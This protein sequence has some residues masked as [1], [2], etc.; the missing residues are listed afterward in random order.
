MITEHFSVGVL[1]ATECVLLILTVY[2]W[3]KSKSEN[4]R[5]VPF[6]R[7][8][9]LSACACLIEIIYSSLVN[10]HY[11]MPGIFY[12]SLYELNVF[13]GMIATC[14]LYLYFVQFLD[15]PKTERR[16]LSLVRHVVIAAELVILL[17]NFVTGAVVRYNTSGYFVMGPLYDTASYV[18]PFYFIIIIIILAVLHFRQFD[19]K[20]LVSF[21]IVTGISVLFYPIQML[22]FPNVLTEYFI[23]GLFAVVMFFA[24]ETSPVNLLLDTEQRLEEAYAKT[25]RA[26]RAALQAAHTKSDFLSNMSHEIRTPMNAIIGMNDMILQ[27]TKS[28][29]TR[30]YAEEIRDSGKHL[31]HVINDILDYSR[32]ESGRTEIRIGA[33]SLSD[34]LRRLFDA[35]KE[36]AKDKGLSFSVDAD[37]TLP[38]SLIG[39]EDRLFQ[40]VCNLLENAVKYTERGSVKLT[41][42]G[43]R[44]DMSLTLF[45]KVSDTGI[46]IGKESLKG[47]FESFSRAN[48]ERNRNILGTGLGLAITKELVSMM[49]GDISVRSEEG[50]GSTFTIRIAQKILSDVPGSSVTDFLMHTGREEKESERPVY[51]GARVLIVDDNT[52]NLR[53][54]S[55]LLK[56]YGIDAQIASSGEACL[57][58]CADAHFD[59]VLLDHLMPE[60]DG[61]QTLRALRSSAAFNKEQTTVV[62]LTAVDDPGAR[63]RFIGMGFDDFLTKPID[64][65]NLE[66]LLSAYLT[67]EH[68]HGI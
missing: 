60:M 48:I 9:T 14:S 4:I 68:A 47:I 32:M 42:N 12:Q 36:S 64:T 2:L 65:K 16:L 53:I 46:G 62:A 61:E 15:A 24:L 25:D 30:A 43:V 58:E 39:D 67:K 41:V 23:V 33:Y 55:M 18:L 10:I 38:D 51:D 29:Q 31:L 7:F 49:G 45:F 17:A 52:V 50:V 11:S 37:R 40:V 59:I 13:M 34:L 57:K 27:E 21:G 6:R 44:R 8:V 63:E 3:S 35:V 26:T 19:K 28:V 5:F 54:A 22:F 1:C 66:R 56:P 20:V